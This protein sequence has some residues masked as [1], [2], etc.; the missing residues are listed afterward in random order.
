MTVAAVWIGVTRTGVSGMDSFGMEPVCASAGI[1]VVV[2][3]VAAAAA[4]MANV[5]T[6]SIFLAGIGG[7]FSADCGGGGKGSCK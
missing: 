7:T 5:S 1:A 3:T 4:F 6:F 2:G